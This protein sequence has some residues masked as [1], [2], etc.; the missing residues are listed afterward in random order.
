MSKTA[1]NYLQLD[2]ILNYALRELDHL[3]KQETEIV[4]NVFVTSGISTRP[5]LI[6]EPLRKEVSKV[7]TLTLRLSRYFCNGR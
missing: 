1:V 4:E 2:N 3:Q 5:E 6:I 7:L